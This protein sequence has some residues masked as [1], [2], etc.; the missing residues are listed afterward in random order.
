MWPVERDLYQGMGIYL[1]QEKEDSGDNDEL[2]AGK[3]TETGE[4]NDES[5]RGEG[6][7]NLMKKE[8]G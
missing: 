7:Q 8:E 6:E 4:V 5:W 3:R 1:V 2:F